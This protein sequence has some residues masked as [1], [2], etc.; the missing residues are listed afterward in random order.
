[1]FSKKIEC[2]FVLAAGRGE[3]LRPL[4]DQTLKPLLSVNGKPLLDHVLENLKVLG[5]KRVVLN[6][7]HLKEQ[8]QKYVTERNKRF[9]FELV[10]SLEE[11]LLGTGGGLKKALPLIGESPFL[12]LNADCLWRGN[13]QNF[14]ETSLSKNDV[15]AVWWLAPVEKEQT[16]I[17]VQKEKIVQIGNLWG[18]QKGEKEGCFTGIRFIHQMDAKELPSKGCIIRDYWIPRLKK[19]KNL[20]STFE[21]LEQWTDIGTVERYQSLAGC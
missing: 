14:V 9:G 13:I 16:V 4:T 10:V 20:G 8:L 17:S 18:S 15:E 6:A 1:M 19:G 5:L 12:M 11:E 3:R 7:W 21:G 2:A